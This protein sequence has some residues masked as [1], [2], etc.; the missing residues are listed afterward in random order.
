LRCFDLIDLLGNRESIISRPADLQRHT[1]SGSPPEAM[2]N[3]VQGKR[4]GNERP[5]SGDGE[6]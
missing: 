3:A 6:V 2:S 4:F 1:L 5:K